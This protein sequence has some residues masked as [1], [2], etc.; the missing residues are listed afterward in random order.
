MGHRLV[1]WIRKRKTK[2]EREAWYLWESC[3]RVLYN[4][5]YDD[6]FKVE[7]DM[8]IILTGEIKRRKYNPHKCDCDKTM[9]LLHYQIKDLVKDLKGDHDDFYD[10]RTWILKCPGRISQS[11]TRRFLELKSK[12]PRC[13]IVAGPVI[14]WKENSFS[15]KFLLNLAQLLVVK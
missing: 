5:L 11:Q 14:I 15:H 12:K 13:T 8:L 1:G 3:R 2:R 6:P 9:I 7:W 4:L 10:F